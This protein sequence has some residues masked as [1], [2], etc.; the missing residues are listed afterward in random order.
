MPGDRMVGRGDD[1]RSARRRDRVEREHPVDRRVENA[2]GSGDGQPV[3]SGIAAGH[4]R[5]LVRT[6]QVGD[7]R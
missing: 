1:Q 3:I 6:G 4:H 7:R 5:P 2:E